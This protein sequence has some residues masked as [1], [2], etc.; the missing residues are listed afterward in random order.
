MFLFVLGCNLLLLYIHLHSQ[1]LELATDYSAASGPWISTEA[2]LD[3]CQIS[4]SHPMFY[5]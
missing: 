4:Y 3:L 5:F 1:T 2:E